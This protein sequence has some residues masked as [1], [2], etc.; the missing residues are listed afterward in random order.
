MTSTSPV[1][2]AARP[3]VV[4]L[5]ETEWRISDPSQRSTDALSVVGFIQRTGDLFE[6]TAIGRPRE[7]HYYGSFDEAL[8]S[9][10][11]APAQLVS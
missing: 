10:G 9:L 8:L 7:R 5:P 11:V 2:H 1:S 3:G 6:V 4:A